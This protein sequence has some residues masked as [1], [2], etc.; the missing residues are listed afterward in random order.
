MSDNELHG[1]AG[2]M[3]VFMWVCVQG[4]EVV[5]LFRQKDYLPK[6]QVCCQNSPNK[7]E[8]E[9]VLSAQPFQQG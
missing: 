7:P 6:K 4:G 1:A 5:C 9:R 8:V 3:C 2:E